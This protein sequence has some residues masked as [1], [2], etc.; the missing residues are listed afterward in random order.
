MNIRTQIKNFLIGL[1]VAASGVAV[2][3]T[4]NLFS[5]ATGVLKGNASTYVTTAANS[6]DIRG[7]WTG[8]CDI[9]KFL[10]GDG[11]CAQVSL[12]T[13]VTGILPV[14]NGGTGAATLTGLMQGN[15]ASPITSVAQVS[16]GIPYFN[17]VSTMASS[18][19]LTANALM[20]G[21]GVGSSP[22]TLGSLGTTTTVLH[23]N[24]AGAPTFGA[25]ALTTD[26]SGVLPVA[27]GGTNLNVSADDNVMVGN[28]TTWQSKALPTCTDTGG[29]HLNYDIST[30]T[31]SCGTSAPGG[32][33]GFAN[34]TASVGLSAVNGV[35]TTAMRSDA[36]PALSQSI[37][38]TWT[39]IHTFSA[40]NAAPLTVTNSFTGSYTV[41]VTNTSTVSGDTSRYTLAAGSTAVALFAAN[42]NQAAAIV[43]GGPTGP[44]FVLRTL[45]ASTPLVFGTAN[46]ERMRISDTGVTIGGAPVPT[47]KFTWAKF[48]TA[49]AACV[50]VAGTGSSNVSS[51][52]YSG[53]GAYTV[54]FTANYP[55][56]PTCTAT[57]ASATRY[58]TVGS[59]TSQAILAQAIFPG[60]GAGDGIFSLTCIGNP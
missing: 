6:A 56:A 46:T 19:A 24:A 5:P 20:L 25:V 15:G 33:T 10:R 45:G 17:T 59:S 60:G 37:A 57:S 32:L 44:Q 21:G 31:F 52:T 38:P 28:G 4:F 55:S 42:Q 9:T 50:V 30:N 58:I 16:G 54:N 40:N 13:N 7:L 35:A 29:N 43:T 51:C 1:T 11:A 48:D 18:A 8:S 36:A 22:T 2:A 39:G 41:N 26:V 23:G 12:T 14:P 53:V 47:W 27:N 49:G 3:A 34:P